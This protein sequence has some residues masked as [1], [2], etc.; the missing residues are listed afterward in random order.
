[1]INASQGNFEIE[2]CSSA[3]TVTACK[4]LDCDPCVCNCINDPG[5]PIIPFDG[6]FARF[7]SL[8]AKKFAQT[9]NS[10]ET[11]D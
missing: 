3:Q 4:T 11:K 5:L 10:E 6:F 7:L 9:R 1:M 8:A 2:I